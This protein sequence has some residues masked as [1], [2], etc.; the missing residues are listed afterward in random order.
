MKQVIFWEQIRN[1]IYVQFE[2][3]DE[4]D[5]QIFVTGIQLNSLNN[6]IMKTVMEYGDHVE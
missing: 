1:K 4:E 2:D 5:C 6:I 3:N